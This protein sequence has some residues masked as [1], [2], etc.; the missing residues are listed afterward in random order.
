MLPKSIEKTFLLQE[1][2]KSITKL[3]NQWIGTS[4]FW[5]LEYDNQFWF[6]LISES[7]M[8]LS[9]LV[10]LRN[11]DWRTEEKKRATEEKADMVSQK[12]QIMVCYFKKNF[13]LLHNY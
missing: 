3:S 13:N 9:N 10:Y 2:F 11:H 1:G 5:Y 6:H 4:F 12:Y 8:N 7:M